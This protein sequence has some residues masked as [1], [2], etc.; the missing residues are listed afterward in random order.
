MI[1]DP[2]NQGSSGQLRFTKPGELL[3]PL[4]TMLWAL[5]DRERQ[6]MISPPRVYVTQNAAQIGA[7]RLSGNRG[8]VGSVVAIPLFGDPP[9]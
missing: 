1:P 4:R 8:R 7:A 3:P 2:P 9:K 5:W 6:R